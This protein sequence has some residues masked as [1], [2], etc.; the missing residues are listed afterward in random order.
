M[1][2]FY[3]TRKVNRGHGRPLLAV[4]IAIAGECVVH[5]GQSQFSVG[6]SLPPTFTA[7]IRLS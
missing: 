5:I 2:T 4:A 1:F 7:L 6:A 3:V